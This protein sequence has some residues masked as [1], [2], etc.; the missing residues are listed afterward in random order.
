MDAAAA[1]T[2]K[3]SVEGPVLFLAFELGN[4][5]WKLGFSVGFGQRPR[6]RTIPARDLEGLQREIKLAKT[7]FGLPETARVMSCYEAGRDGFWLHR[8]LVEAGVE[9][10]VVDSSS[11]QVDRRFRRA[12]TDRIQSSWTNGGCGQAARSADAV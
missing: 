3:Y 1:R 2:R 11:I 12:K 4:K 6:V 5:E 10:L 8:Y 7:R 9:N